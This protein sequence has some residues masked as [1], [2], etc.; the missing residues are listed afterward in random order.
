VKVS[1]NYIFGSLINEAITAIKLA[2]VRELE[3]DWRRYNLRDLTRRE[4]FYWK[5]IR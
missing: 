2:E 1:W 3:G 4:L 5:K